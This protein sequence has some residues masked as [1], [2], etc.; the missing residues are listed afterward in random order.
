M[1]EITATVRIVHGDL[2]C[3]K[4][5]SRIVAT[6]DQNNETY[7]VKKEPKGYIFR[8]VDF[9]HGICGHHKTLRGL[10]ISTLFA[11]SGIHIRVEP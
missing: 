8:E 10:I 7:R 9:G 1:T 4:N 5:L 2:I 3:E 6:S 11:V